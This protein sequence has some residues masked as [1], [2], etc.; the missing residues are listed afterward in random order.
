MNAPV[1]KEFFTIYS[2]LQHLRTT[3]FLDV[4]LVNSFELTGGYML[5]LSTGSQRNSSQRGTIEVA[6]LNHEQNKMFIIDYM[7][8]AHVFDM[9]N[10]LSDEQFHESVQQNVQNYEKMFLKYKTFYDNNPRI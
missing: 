10:E 8:F 4:N 7:S 9:F 6:L 3:L 1:K 5:S 2:L